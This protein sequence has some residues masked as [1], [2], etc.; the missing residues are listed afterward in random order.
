M[1]R[2]TIFNSIRS[3]SRFINRSF[4]KFFSTVPPPEDEWVVRFDGKSRGNPGIGGCS[5][6]LLRIENGVE[7]DIV[8]ASCPAPSSVSTVVTEYFGLNLGLQLAIKL[9]L[10]KLYVEGD[11]RLVMRQLTGVYAIRDKELQNLYSKTKDL[12]KQIPQYTFRQITRDQ[13]RKA[14]ALSLDAITRQEFFAQWL[15]SGEELKKYAPNLKTEELVPEEEIEEIHE[16]RKENN[17]TEQIESH[18]II[19]EDLELNERI[20]AR[21]E[22][23][24]S[25]FSQSSS[26][27]T[28]DNSKTK[29]VQSK[30]PNSKLL[31]KRVSS[32]KATSKSGSGEKSLKGPGNAKLATKADT[33]KTPAA[34]SVNK[35]SA[36]ISP[37]EQKDEVRSPKK[38]QIKKISSVVAKDSSEVATV[39]KSKGPANTATKSKTPIGAKTKSKTVA[40]VKTNSVT[41]ADTKTK[42]KTVADTASKLKTVMDTKITDTKMKPKSTADSKTKSISCA[43][44]FKSR[45]TLVCFAFARPRPM[46]D[47]LH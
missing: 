37:Q 19:K 8:H 18:Q 29:T 1:I 24:E 4:P 28:A 2:L 38:T 3:S 44:Y 15:V 5:A 36:A 11:S 42:S 40:E 20:R 21:I 35:K 14:D 41:S 43:L 6:I 25:Q 31:V 47:L 12:L 17:E 46:G 45:A 27:T 16:I 32:K 34:K 13:N 30:K 10:E 26:P 7:K 39:A 22:S 33:K 9:N 23:L